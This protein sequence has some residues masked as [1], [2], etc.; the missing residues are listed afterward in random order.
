MSPDQDW[1]LQCGA[2]APGSLSSGSWR[3]AGA[4]LLAAAVLALA[5]A[6]AAVAALGKHTKPHSTTVAVVHVP[7]A[8]TP[9]VTAAPATPSTPVPVT[10]SLTTPAVKTPKVPVTPTVP[11]TTVKTTTTPTTSTPTTSTTTEASEE[12]PETQS[13][14]LLDTNAAST[15]NPYGYPASG[16]GDPSL[17]IDGDPSTAWTAQVQPD[18]APGMAVGVLVN[19]G[20]SRKLAAVELISTTLGMRVQFYG[21]TATKAPNSITDPAWVPLSHSVLTSKKKTHLKL[22][23][24][25]KAFKQVVLWISR[26]PASAVGTERAPAHVDVNEI[27]LF[28]AG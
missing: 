14:L 5:A 6:G 9:A 3:S 20:S 12:T 26:A 8:S 25:N 7:A 23:N 24:S 15:Y 13:A 28:P 11:K 17:T 10:P 1:C 4:M 18:K 16:Y 19:L 21:T 2:G 27:E 22:L